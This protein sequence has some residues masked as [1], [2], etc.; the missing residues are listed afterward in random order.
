MNPHHWLNATRHTEQRLRSRHSYTVGIDWTDL[1]QEALT[2]LLEQQH[3]R[4]S[5]KQYTVSDCA[6]LLTRIAER[7]A[8]DHWRKY[9]S[10]LPVSAIESVDEEETI[11]TI[12]TSHNQI[13]VELQIDLQDVFSRIDTYSRN[14]FLLHHEGYS[15]SDI[16]SKLCISIACAQKRYERTTAIL[17]KHL[18]AYR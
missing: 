4:N 9:N 13:H 12:D 3:L 8:I 18:L 11:D 1:V 16:A 7:L 6:N 15:F 2:R 14:V 17:R 10:M 5:Q